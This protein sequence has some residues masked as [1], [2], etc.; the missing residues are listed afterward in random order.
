MRRHVEAFRDLA[1]I[2]RAVAESAIQN[3]PSPR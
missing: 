2:G 1:L 3:L